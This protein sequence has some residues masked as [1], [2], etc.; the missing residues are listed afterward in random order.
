MHRGGVAMRDRRHRAFVSERVFCRAG[1]PAA[2]SLGLPTLFFA[3]LVAACLCPSSAFCYSP[4][5]PVVKQM[6]AKGLRF[7]QED[8]RAGLDNRLGGRCLVGLALIKLDQRA[9]PAVAEA[10]LS[11][12]GVA[13]LPLE[14]ITYSEADMYSLGIAVM[15]LCEHDPLKNRKTIDK[16]M[17]LFQKRMKQYGG[18]GY[19]HAME[20]DTSMTQYGA[21]AYWTVQNNGI[22][23]NSNVVS[24]LG[25]WLVGTQDP[26]GN[27]GYQGQYVNLPES[28]QLLTQD[29]RSSLCMSAAAMASLAI[30]VD[31]AGLNVNVSDRTYIPK[32][33]RR[34]GDGGGAIQVDLQLVKNAVRRHDAWARKNWRIQSDDYQYYYMYA[35]ERYFSFRELAFGSDYPFKD[36]WYDQGV[37]YL[38]ERQADNGSW[39]SSL[40]VQVDTAFALLFLSRSTKKT[41]EKL[42]SFEGGT[43]KGGRGLANVRNEVLPSDAAQNKRKTIGQGDELLALLKDP[44]NPEVYYLSENLEQIDHSLPS[45]L[46]EADL[47]ALSDSL[48]DSNVAVRLIAVRSLAKAGNFAAAPRL[49]YALSDPDPRVKAE[50]NSAL[51]KICNILVGFEL[52]DMNVAAE[53][54][55][56]IRKWKNHILSIRP[57]AVFVE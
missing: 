40:G 13:G 31:M 18:W 21:M 19:D 4:E 53:R 27:W 46:G 28:G 34:K 38:L 29:G 25:G 57:D 6:V 33:L 5:S 24:R 49:V 17:E 56:H 22:R 8:A 47:E 7:L 10:L 1:L 43:L 36:G 37:E 50:A 44:D 2:N 32:V 52:P 16:F 23:V 39:E 30:V 42:R 35:L 26:K 20:G 48:G 12:E 54:E 55:A 45:S 15:F 11:C 51:R 14:E 9:H 3:V 41:L